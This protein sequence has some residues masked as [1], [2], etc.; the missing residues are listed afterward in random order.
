MGG[1][2][3]RA[4][5]HCEDLDRVE[6]GFNKV[7]EQEGFCRISVLP[8]LELSPHQAPFEDIMWTFVYPIT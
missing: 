1:G 5:I 4:Y 7:M 8:P 3:E 6:Q 2:S